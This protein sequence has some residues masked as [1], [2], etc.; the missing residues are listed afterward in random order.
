MNLKPIIQR[1]VSQ[2]EENE[3]HIFM[4]TDGISKDGTDEPIAGQQ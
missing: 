4:R 3:Y 1:E 2:K